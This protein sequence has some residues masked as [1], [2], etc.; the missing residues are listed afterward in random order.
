MDTS[1]AVKAFENLM[2]GGK[3]SIALNSPDG[4]LEKLLEAVTNGS[5][6]KNLIPKPINSG[7]E[8][9]RW[10]RFS[11]SFNLNE[12]EYQ[13]LLD[14]LEE[15][16]PATTEKFCEKPLVMDMGGGIAIPPPG[17]AAPAT[18]VTSFD[19][20]SISGHLLND[21]DKCA[22]AQGIPI[23][24][25]AALSFLL[26]TGSLPAGGD[27]LR[28]GEDPRMSQAYT[29]MRKTGMTM[30]QQYLD[31]EN[32]QLIQMWFRGCQ[33]YAAENGKPQMA[34]AIAMFWSDTEAGF[35]DDVKVL[36]LYIEK[37][38]AKYP[39]RGLPCSRDHKLFM[40]LKLIDSSNE[41]E[42]KRSGSRSAKKTEGDEDMHE[43]LKEMKR[44]MAEIKIQN[45]RLESRVGGRQFNRTQDEEEAGRDGRT[46]DYCGKRGHLKATC[47]EKKKAE[48]KKKEEEATAEEDE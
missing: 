45:K 9:R 15:E 35:A 13:G 41:Q 39:G 25:L 24:E 2:T 37:Y 36:V 7:V 16:Y 30:L 40:D 22:Q 27:C 17:A 8:G 29:R 10:R 20:S 48:K 1:E 47:R 28:P 4:L 44:E 18:N 23:G 33:T 31:K 21:V 12:E 3:G 38:L 32:V 26:F 46:C 14:W 6:G 34:S 43:L 5:V 19:M 42:G 11:D